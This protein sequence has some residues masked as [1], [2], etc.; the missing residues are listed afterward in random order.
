M[1]EITHVLGR[2]E[3]DAPEGG[4]AVVLDRRYATDAADLWQA[5]TDPDRLARWFAR[6]SGD[7]H[8][9][10]DFTIHF[11]DADTPRCRVVSCEAPSRLVW[12]WPVGE[13]TTVVTVEVAPAADGARLVLRHARLG[14]AQ[15]AGYAAGWDTY[16][17]RLDADL[18]GKVLPDWD[19]TWSALFAR[20]G[21][22]A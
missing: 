2:I 15:V 22:G 11:D 19:A 7:L 13:V 5:C 4:V 1:S 16:V 20:Y 3:K 6:V 8:E 14:E 12:E 9:G 21:A 18:A 10:G 17:R